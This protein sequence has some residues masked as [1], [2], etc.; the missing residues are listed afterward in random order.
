MRWSAVTADLAE[1]AAR[2]AALLR[3]EGAA[4]G[5]ERAARFARAVVL[6]A[7]ESTGELYRCALATLV[8]SPAEIE[9][10]DR[11]FAAVFSESVEQTRDLVATPEPRQASSAGVAVPSGFGTSAP[12]PARGAETERSAEVATRASA[13]ER[14]ASRDFGE[15]TPDEL[16]RLADLM[17]RFRISTPPRRSRRRRPA[18]AGRGVDLR[19]TLRQARRTGAEPVLLRHS[20]RRQKPRKLVV[21]CDISG[22]MAANARAMLQLLYCAAGGARAEVFTFATRLT[23]ITRVL[24][25][26]PERA[27]RQAGETAPDWSGGTRIGAAVR[28]FVDS[29]GARGMARGAVVVIISDGWETGDTAELD[30]QLARL[31]RL[32]YRIVWANPRTASPRY[33]PLVGGMAAAWPYCDAVVSAHRLD[34]IDELIAAIAAP[35]R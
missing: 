17:R 11:V 23:R 33:R 7:P 6:L 18:R 9:I 26:H 5:V 34:A 22:S 35:V 29:Y 3:T 21:L 14:L 20:T 4:V 27:L 24:A 32:A 2:F 12:E 19:E 13:A 25:A 28:D 10:L 31:S 8:A 30:T 1:V 16:A 15:L